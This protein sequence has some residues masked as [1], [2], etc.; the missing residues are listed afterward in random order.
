MQTRRILARNNE[1]VNLHLMIEMEPKTF[2]EASKSEKWM[3]AMEEELR[4]IENSKTWELVPRLANK[5]IIGTKWVNQNKM[6]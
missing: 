2:N 1:Q 6:N 4:H 5:N 3:D